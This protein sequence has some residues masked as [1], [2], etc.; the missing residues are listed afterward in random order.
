ME[1]WRQVEIGGKRA[2]VLDFSSGPP[3]FAVIYLHT[4]NKESLAENEVFSRALR[5]L[6]IGCVCPSGERCWWAD[7]VCPEFDPALS[8]ERYVVEQVLPFITERWQL[9]PRAV[10]LIGVDMGGQGGL[11]MAFKY[12]QHFTTVGAIAPSIE[13]HELYWSGTPIDEMYTSKEQCRQD[14][15]PM[16]IHP[17]NFPPHIF[18]ASDPTDPWHRGSERLHEKLLALGVTHEC[19]LTTRAGGHTWP[20]FNHLAQRAL[21]FVV[22][23]L[24]R[25]SRRLI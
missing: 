2:S 15:A 17:S 5:E 12:P 6:K 8:P 18:F 14:T 10:G 11:R 3:Q 16:H 20:Y 23:G 25:E 24:E 7:R 19:E 13:Y 4:Y 21:R 1:S 9:A 22:A